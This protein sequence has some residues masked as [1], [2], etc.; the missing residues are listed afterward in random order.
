M[1]E[2][3]ESPEKVAEALPE[4]AIVEVIEF[5]FVAICEMVNEMAVG[6]IIARS[7]SADNETSSS[8]RSRLR[9]WNPVGNEPA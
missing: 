8:P 1:V 3:L 4:T 9:R 6:G 2:V 7:N 5:V